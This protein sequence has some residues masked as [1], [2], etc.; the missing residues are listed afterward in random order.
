MA[1]GISGRPLA[2]LGTT[3]GAPTFILTQ[4]ITMTAATTGTSETSG[5]LSVASNLGFK[6]RVL[7]ID[8]CATAV[9]NPA[10][11]ATAPTV[12]VYAGTSSG[13]SL[14]TSALSLSTAAVGGVVN[15]KFGAMK[16]GV[17]VDVTAS[18]PLVAKIVIA[19]SGNLE[20]GDSWTLRLHLV[21]V[22]V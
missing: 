7:E 20:V 1:R 5:D 21:C 6:Y 12:Q 4:D 3:L 18:Q 16:A 15:S 11:T 9:T 13:T 8:A 10:G 17:F 22:K 19:E 14:T 2:R